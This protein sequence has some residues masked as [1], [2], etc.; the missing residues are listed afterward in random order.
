MY[1]FICILVTLKIN[2]FAI[3]RLH[4]YLYLYLYLYFCLYSH[5]IEEEYLQISIC[6]C[7]F[8]DI[9]TCTCVC[10]LITFKGNICKF[11]C[12]SLPWV[13]NWWLWK[14]IPWKMQ[15]A[16]ISCKADII[17][18]RKHVFAKLLTHCMSLIWILSLLSGPTF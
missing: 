7:I 18:W 8:I 5:N 6:I 12:P 4:L 17:V 15:T 1:V 2:I 9:C 11:P 10:I 13:P 3:S 14:Y 16:H